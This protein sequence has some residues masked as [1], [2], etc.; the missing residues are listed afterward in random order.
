MR[1][2]RCCNLIR[3]GNWLPAQSCTRRRSALGADA[4]GDGTHPFNRRRIGA[5]R[6]FAI[7][8]WVFG[9]GL[10]WRC[11]LSAARFGDKVGVA[12][13]IGTAPLA[14]VRPALRRH[15]ASA[16]RFHLHSDFTTSTNSEYIKSRRATT[17]SAR[18]F[19]V[20]LLRELCVAID[21]GVGAGAKTARRST[22]NMRAQ[23][24]CGIFQDGFN[25]LEIIACGK[26]LAPHF[27]SMR[28]ND[29]GNIV[30]R[31]EGG[32]YAR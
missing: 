23:I 25:D 2:R 20:C 10:R 16:G 27:R 31:V 5:A 7:G 18:L 17:L 12:L 29:R 22:G 19:V 6:H 9:H 3:I 1:S 21:V 24:L 15:N 11:I 8:V 30:G 13:A 4:M 26:F 32:D 14:W 28:T